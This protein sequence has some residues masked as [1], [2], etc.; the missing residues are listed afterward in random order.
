LPEKLGGSEAATRAWQGLDHYAPNPHDTGLT[1]ARSVDEVVLIGD[2]ISHYAPVLIATLSIGIRRAG[3]Q[4]KFVMRRASG[5]PHQSWRKPLR[6]LDRL[7][8]LSLRS[9][10]ASIW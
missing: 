1:T 9:A 3:V 5:T 7:G 10:L 2:T 6:I 4:K 8:F